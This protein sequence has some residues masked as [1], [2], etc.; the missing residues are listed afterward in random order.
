MSDEIV[1][2]YYAAKG[3]PEAFA[4]ARQEAIAAGYI[5]VDGSLSATGRVKDAP[6]PMSKADWDKKIAPVAKPSAKKGDE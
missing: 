1:K 6:S 4:K 5:E 3:N 2:A